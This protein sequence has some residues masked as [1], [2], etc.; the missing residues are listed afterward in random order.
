[1]DPA[2]L[3]YLIFFI[4]IENTL[5]G[6][7]AKGTFDIDQPIYVS[8]ITGTAEEATLEPPP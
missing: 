1:M 3:R 5:R 8:V 6:T 7:K 4:K 2:N